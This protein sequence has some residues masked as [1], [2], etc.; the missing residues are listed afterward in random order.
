MCSERNQKGDGVSEKAGEKREVRV[1]CYSGYQ[2]Q[3][4]PR[5]FFLDERKIEVVSIA[6]RWR[7]PERECFK[8]VGD[9]GGEYLLA[10]DTASDTWRVE[11]DL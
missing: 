1:E 5:R 3:E 2:S 4:N 8:V 10:R 11:P 6:A 9:D 7:A